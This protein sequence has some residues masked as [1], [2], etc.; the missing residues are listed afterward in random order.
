M[1]HQGDDL[2]LLH[3][4]EDLAGILKAERLD[5]PAVPSIHMPSSRGLMESLSARIHTCDLSVWP[6]FPPN[7]VAAFQGQAHTRERGRET[8]GNHIACYNLTLEVKQRHF[9]DFD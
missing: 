3:T 8:S 2:P 5:V 9:F 7:M 4:S 1:G 6:V